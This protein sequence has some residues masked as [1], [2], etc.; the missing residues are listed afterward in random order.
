MGCNSSN[1]IRIVT[2]DRTIKTY[3]FMV[4]CLTY[5]KDHFIT[6]VYMS[7]SMV[8]LW[9]RSGYSL[10]MYRNMLSYGCNKCLLF[11]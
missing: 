2:E 7:D 5:F 6:V 1:I 11:K 3:G 8:K 9:S 4:S 10:N